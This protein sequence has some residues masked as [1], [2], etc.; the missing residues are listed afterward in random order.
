MR[1]L[2]RVLTT[3]CGCPGGPSIL[4]CLQDN[5][6]RA[7]WVHGVDMDLDAIEEDINNLASTTSYDTEILDE[8]GN[9]IDELFIEPDLLE[10][11]STGAIG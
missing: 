7:V 5:G 4:K 8:I 10:S 1:A 9:Q 3:A 6:E 2:L 11:I